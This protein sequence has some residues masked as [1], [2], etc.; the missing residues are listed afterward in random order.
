MEKNNLP[1]KFLKEED[2]LNLGA[3][4]LSEFLNFLLAETGESIKYIIQNYT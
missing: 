2:F 3:Y 4:E 1:I